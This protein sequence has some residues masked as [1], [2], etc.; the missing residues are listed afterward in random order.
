MNPLLTWRLAT[1]AAVALGGLISAADGQK[2]GAEET[3][4]MA[5][6][7]D[8]SA[9]AVTDSIIPQAKVRSSI[10]QVRIDS[11]YK[12]HSNPSTEYGEV[13]SEGGNHILLKNGDDGY[14]IRDHNRNGTTTRDTIK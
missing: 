13:T 8:N 3:K 4:Q 2:S 9:S 12:A 7:L 1:H 10:S 14:E 6:D 11:A 5:G